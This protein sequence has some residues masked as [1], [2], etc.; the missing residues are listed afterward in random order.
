[1]GKIENKDL[2]R[3]STLNKA[4]TKKKLVKP[5][6]EQHHLTINISRVSKT[7]KDDVSLSEYQDSKKSRLWELLRSNIL[8]VIVICAVAFL[9]FLVFIYSSRAIQ[10]LR[11][12]KNSIFAFC[13]IAIGPTPRLLRTIEECLPEVDVVLCSNMLKQQENFSKIKISK[14]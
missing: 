5:A 8:L 12:L 13:T 7:F 10:R 2:L 1:M 11:F 14:V 3:K 9:L 4:D 6:Q